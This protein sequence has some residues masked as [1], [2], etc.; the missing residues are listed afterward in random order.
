MIAIDPMHK[1][2]G[3]LTGLFIAALALTEPSPARAA[4]PEI[5]APRWAA[6]Q[7]KQMGLKPA[8][9]AHGYQ[10]A[11][12]IKGQAGRSAQVVGVIPGSDPLLA[13][14]YVLVS[15]RLDAGGATALIETAHA[16]AGGVT[17][18]RRSVIFVL[19][20][21]EGADQRAS[22]PNERI[23]ADVDLDAS[24]E[25]GAAAL[26]L[27]AA[28]ET[29]LGRDAGEL[30]AA[31]GFAVVKADIDTGAYGALSMGAPTISIGVIPD[32]A[33][34]QRFS[35]YLT[36]LVSRVAE[37]DERP[38]WS[39]GSRFAP[40]APRAEQVLTDP[41]DMPLGRRPQPPSQANG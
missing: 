5:G 40:P 21:I 17:A 8:P 41:V 25:A 30:A 9:G 23:V 27:K 31:A 3:A 14:D 35:D 20:A 38:A 2:A 29:S 6:D 36:A 11:V 32:P 22:T 7:F 1:T 10:S 34:A 33:N 26:A 12:R 24:S 19:S 13:K 18:P 28:D 37:R 4:E 39:P 16:L 15:A